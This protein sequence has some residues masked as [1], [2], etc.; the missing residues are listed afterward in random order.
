M[1]ETEAERILRV[2]TDS[3]S[4]VALYVAGHEV[5]ND[6][7]ASSDLDGIDDWESNASAVATIREGTVR[8]AARK[9]IPLELRYAVR[10]S[11]ESCRL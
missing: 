4:K 11:H 6:L 2:T 7:R 5:F 1:V 10:A 8:L 3:N 9:L